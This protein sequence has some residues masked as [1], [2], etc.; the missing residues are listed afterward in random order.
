MI[1]IKAWYGFHD[2]EDL[3]RCAALTISRYSFK[4]FQNDAKC[5]ILFQNVPKCSKKMQ[6]DEK[7]SILFQNVPK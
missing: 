5:S 7:C 1:H 3:A 2:Q 6:N 4:L